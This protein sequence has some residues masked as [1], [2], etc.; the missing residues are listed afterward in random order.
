MIQAIILPVWDEFYGENT[1]ISDWKF[2]LFKVLQI[3]S[4]ITYY[5]LNQLLLV[6]AIQIHRFKYDYQLQ[7]QSMLDLKEAYFNETKT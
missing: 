1:E 5:L 6:M 7:I 3:L 2:T 4:C